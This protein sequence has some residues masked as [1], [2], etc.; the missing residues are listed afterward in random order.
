MRGEGCN[1]EKE[2]LLELLLGD[3]GPPKARRTGLRLDET[4]S[5]NTDNVT[6]AAAFTDGLTFETCKRCYF[7]SSL[8]TSAAGSETEN[9]S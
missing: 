3:E 7:F 5:V 2:A 4:R 8:W 9:D 1:P 6:T